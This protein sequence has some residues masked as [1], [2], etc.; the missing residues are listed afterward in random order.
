MV[1]EGEYGGIIYVSCPAR[2]V[3]CDEVDL[4]RL[5]AD[6]DSCFA[7]EIRGARVVFR[8]LPIGS[9]VAG[10]GGGGLMI[11]GVWL[12]GDVRDLGLESRVR[13]TLLGKA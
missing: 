10:G 11:D 8:S 7:D 6:I 1:L 3:V 13:R 2:L 5:L 9:V 4:R 12:H